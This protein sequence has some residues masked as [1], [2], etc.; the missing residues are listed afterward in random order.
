MRSVLALAL[1]ITLV[2]VEEEIEIGKASDAQVRRQLVVLRDAPTNDYVKTIGRRLAR[3]ADGPKY[4]YTFAVVNDGDVNAF[5]LPGGPVWINRGALRM[6]ANESQVAAVLAHEIAHVAR[7]HAAN[8]LTKAMIANWGLGL[9]GA[10]LGNSGGANAA[11]VAARLMANGA[12]LTF[13][14]DDERDADRVGLA[15]MT[16]AGWDG[17]GM[18]EMLESLQRK[19][20]QDPGAVAVLVSTHPPPADRVRLL[21]REPATAHRGT[22]DTDA[23]KALHKRLNGLAPPPRRQPASG[24]GSER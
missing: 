8:Q 11:Q 3:N 12:F 14:R 2:G 5:A 21:R 23:F 17:R 24:R 20:K 10:V 4:P 9:L 7:R 1:A 6:A 19:T 16:R 13:S 15:I 18:I 22:R